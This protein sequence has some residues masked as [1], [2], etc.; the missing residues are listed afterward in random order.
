MT[1]K[2]EFYAEEMEEN[3]EESPFSEQDF[4]GPISTLVKDFQAA[5]ASEI[6]CDVTINT[7]IDG[8][9]CKAHKAILASRSEVRPLLL[10]NH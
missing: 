4:R 6:L 9:S 8:Y 10:L 2:V 5:L 1:Y 7:C 3:Y